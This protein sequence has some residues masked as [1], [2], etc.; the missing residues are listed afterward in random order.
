MVTVMC[1]SQRDERNLFCAVETDE[2]Q[3]KMT[4]GW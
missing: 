4:V 1:M 2:L 3:I